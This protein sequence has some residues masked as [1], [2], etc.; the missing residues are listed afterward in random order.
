M[1]GEYPAVLNEIA[2]QTVPGVAYKATSREEARRL[3][4][5]ETRMYRKKGCQ[6]N[7]EDGSR[8]LG[9]TFVWDADTALLRERSFDLGAFLEMERKRE[10]KEKEGN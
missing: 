2:Q 7:L 1:Y 10:G 9:A 4:K 3:A 5:Y 8:V 6:V